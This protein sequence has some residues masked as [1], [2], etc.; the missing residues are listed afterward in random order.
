MERFSIVLAFESLLGKTPVT[1]S[2]KDSGQHHHKLA[3]YH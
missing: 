1:N 2:L 3:Q